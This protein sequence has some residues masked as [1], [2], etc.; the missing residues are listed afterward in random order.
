MGAQK[1]PL[2]VI[3]S[4]RNESRLHHFSKNWSMDDAA[5]QDLLEV[6]CPNLTQW[7]QSSVEQGLMIISQAVEA[8]AAQ[9]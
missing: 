6:F 8:I 3:T 2:R 9:S 7:R 5:K 4:L 1:Y